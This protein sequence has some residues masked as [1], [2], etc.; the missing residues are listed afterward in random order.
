MTFCSNCTLQLNFCPN[1]G[2]GLTAKQNKN[3]VFTEAEL[4]EGCKRCVENV[5]GLLNSACLLIKN[6]ASQQYAL[7]LY[8]YAVE[9]FGKA[10]LLRGY[11]T[12]NKE[13]YQ[14]PGWILGKGRP[15]IDSINNDPILKKLLKQLV[16]KYGLKINAHDAKLLIG[17]K[18]LPPECS[19]ITRGIRI[20]DPNPS[21]QTIDLKSNRIISIPKG[22]TGSFADTT[23][24]F[25]D[26]EKSTFIELDLKTSCFYMDFDRDNKTWKYH[27]SP[28]EKQL[29]ENLKRFEKRLDKF[30]C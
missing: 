29:K 11:F 17:S 7:G 28:D 13:K 12:G 9:E 2:Q 23:D 18:N 10:I 15:T 4:R 8:V 14:I 26:A 1:C 25:F 27:I 3:Y 30:N 5:K 16:G 6:R 22:I 21:G 19:M 24:I 20:S